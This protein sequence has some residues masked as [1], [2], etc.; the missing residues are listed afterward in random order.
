MT[1]YR[2]YISQRH[3]GGGMDTDSSDTFASFL[4]ARWCNTA[5]V[6]FRVEDRLLGVAAVDE[7]S[8]GLSS[9][10]TFFDAR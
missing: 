3:S 10:Y 6:E 4:L 7:L 1:L 5:L 8:S 2:Q 9:V